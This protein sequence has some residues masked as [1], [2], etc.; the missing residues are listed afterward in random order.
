VTYDL[1]VWPV[2]RA[3]TVEE[4]IAQVDRL[5]AD[6]SLGLGHDRR[7][8][9]FIAELE[10]RYP[11]IRGRAAEP[12]PCELD[13]MRRHVFLGI[14]WSRV[15]ELVAAVADA[16]WRTGL[17]VY[18]PQRE[19]VGLPAPFADAPLTTRGVDRHTSVAET[20]F[21]AIERGAASAAGDDDAAAE[22][23]VSEEL[24]SAG[25]RQ[26]SP[27]G[28][29]ITP[30]LEAEYHADPARMPSSLQ[31]HE[32][33]TQLILDLSSSAVGARHVAIAQLAGWDPDPEVAAALRPMLAS[34][35]VHEASQAATGLAR[36]GDVTD[37]P[38]VMGLLHRLSP[39]DG[40]TV[41][42]M[43]LALPP[44]LDLAS[45]AGP[46]AVEGVKSR[47]RTWRGD[48]PTRVQPW[49]AEVRRVMDE[50]LDAR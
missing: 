37:L 40:G 10:K 44:A 41:A 38:G 6:F 33:K 36:Q 7:L 21:G 17:A 47:A 23:A 27:L 42:S 16:A 9:R 31:T 49:D 22:R 32:R 8:D 28:F 30:E 15:E 5:D 12:P 4:A 34:E 14:P 45:R 43:L 19:A 20:A 26:L 46:E 35:D 29:V 48:P 2:D 11:G 13:V 3:L 18:D 25:F 24:T 50:L 1:I 39:S